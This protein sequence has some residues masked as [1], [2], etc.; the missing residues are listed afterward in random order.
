[1]SKLREGVPYIEILATRF[2]E[3]DNGIQVDIPLP[4]VYRL[5]KGDRFRWSCAQFV[6]I[7]EVIST[8]GKVEGSTEHCVIAKIN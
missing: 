7:A 5:N 6:G 1:M 3:F 2:Q 8:S 4:A